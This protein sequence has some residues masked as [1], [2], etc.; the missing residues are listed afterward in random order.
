MENGFDS[1]CISYLPIAVYRA[2]ARAR[3]YE[4]VYSILFLIVI[5]FLIK[6]SR[7][8]KQTS[9]LKQIKRTTLEIEWRTKTILE[10]NHGRKS[11]KMLKHSSIKTKKEKN[12]EKW[13]MELMED[14][15]G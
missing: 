13:E 4:N 15:K 11:E 12:K 1:K 6:K 9:L 10:T 2:R 8:E 14:G 3:A 5:L 7:V